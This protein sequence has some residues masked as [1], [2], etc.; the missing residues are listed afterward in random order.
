[1][2]CSGIHEVLRVR[3]EN[4][5]RKIRCRVECGECGANGVLPDVPL[6]CL[7]CHS[8]CLIVEKL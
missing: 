6:E 7:V 8:A 2:S 1:M 3:A 4:V 5:S